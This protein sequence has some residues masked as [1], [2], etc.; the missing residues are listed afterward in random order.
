MKVM[1][2]YLQQAQSLLPS[3]A[4]NSTRLNEANWLLK[5][6]WNLALQ[7]NHYHK[8]MA[9][10][11]IICYQ[12]SSNLP[13]DVSVLRRQRSC[14]LIA[15]AAFVQVAKATD[16]QEEKVINTTFKILYACVCI[17][18]MLPIKFGGV[19]SVK[20]PPPHIHVMCTFKVL[21]SC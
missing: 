18:H 3:M 2:Q 12:L 17:M 11:F 1:L 15:A 10:F 9:D 20:S 21:S 5:V 13:S 4:S 16:I 7:C 6:A 8:E 14:Q 19:L